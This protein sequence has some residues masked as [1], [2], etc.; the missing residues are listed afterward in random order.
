MSEKNSKKILQVSVTI[1]LALFLGQFNL[2]SS[3]ADRPIPSNDYQPL[4]WYLNAVHAPE[5]WSVTKGKGVK[6]AVV[7][8]G[9]Q[10]NHPDLVNRVLPGWSVNT[11]NTD[12][13][14]HGTHVS[15]I[16]AGSDDHA[17][18]VG[19]APEAEIIPIKV[20]GTT[21]GTV[22]DIADGIQKAIELHADVIN[23]S[24]G[25]T[26]NINGGT[27]IC[28]AVAKAFAANI[29]VVASAGNDGQ[30][31][32]PQSQPATC[33][34]VL[35]VA[36]VDESLRPA[37]FSNWDSTVVLAAP[38]KDILSSVTDKSWGYK[39]GT[40]MSA[41]IV[42]GVAALVRAAYPNLSASQV[43]QKLE[44]TATKLSENVPNPSVGYGL[45]NAA[46]ALGL[47]TS[48][49]PNFTNYPIATWNTYPSKAGSYG[50]VTWLYNDNQKI[51]SI[52]VLNIT[53]GESQNLSGDQVRVILPS[54]P[55]DQFTVTF[56]TDQ[57]DLTS[58]PVAEP[59]LTVYDRTLV[60]DLPGTV[61][62]KANWVGH[63]AKVYFQG[64]IDA[65]KN[66][67]LQLV[68][69]YDFSSKDVT[70]TPSD[71]NKGF[72]LIKGFNPT[73]L[74][75]DL[76]ITFNAE[77]Q[78][79]GHTVLKSLYNVGLYPKFAGNKVIN[80]SGTYKF[81]NNK[82]EG[83]HVKIIYTGGITYGTTDKDGE[84]EAVV[85]MTNPLTLKAFKAG[86]LSMSAYV[87]GALS[88]IYIMGNYPYFNFNS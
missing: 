52:T 19:I 26:P 43:I 16:I 56:H 14:G 63:D 37:Y 75:D 50:E 21:G 32:N 87:N 51:N 84:F 61:S 20:F 35:S 65:S 49:K 34:G 33:P 64:K 8:S 71:I 39:D 28:D 46:A 25:A 54:K 36:A 62:V 41:P 10:F 76:T 13:D 40:S 15:G 80:I 45:V 17:G 11:D 12:S 74:T 44:N 69:N 72:I 9:V 30:T 58:F 31:G 18:I 6:V 47:T 23:L 4:E 29:V 73:A 1:V 5:A 7:D 79:V 68:S 48:A 85:N 57:G 2:L 3:Y 66:N 27:L 88:G 59:G 55:D 38:G 22:K 24:L 67:T 77:D 86:K 82:C 81:C 70:L 78:D 60:D 53:T 42:S 83:H